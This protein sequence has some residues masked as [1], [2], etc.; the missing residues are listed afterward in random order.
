[1]TTTNNYQGTEVRKSTTSQYVIF[2][3]GV[4]LPTQKSGAINSNGGIVLRATL[5]TG[6]WIKWRSNDNYGNKGFSFDKPV[7]V[8][9]DDNKTNFINSDLRAKLEYKL[10]D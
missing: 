8:A 6:E 3:E 4:E 10:A 7:V 9:K 1:M 5:P 2:F